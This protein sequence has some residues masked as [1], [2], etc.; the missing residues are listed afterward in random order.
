VGDFST[1]INEAEVYKS[2]GLLEE[3]MGVYRRLLADSEALGPEEEQA[4]REKLEEI[5]KDLED[6]EERGEEGV[7]KEEI[8]VIKESLSAQDNVQTI[9]DAAF[10]F[11]EL[12]LYEEAVGEYTRL[13]GMD[14]PGE[15]VIPEIAKCLMKLHSPE[16]ASEAAVNIIESQALEGRKEAQLKFRL[17]VEMEKVGHPELAIKLYKSALALDPKENR[18]KNRL[19]VLEKRQENAP[20]KRE[21]KPAKS[22][23]EVKDRRREERFIPKIP[24]F[25]FVEFELPDGPLKGKIMR[26]QVLNYSKHGLALLV[27]GKDKKLLELLKPGDKIKNVAFY[28]RW[29]IIKVEVLIKHITRLEDGFHKGHYIIGVESDEII[30]SSR[31]LS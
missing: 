4:I 13:F 9:L 28:A 12:G 5:Q 6:Q 30:E 18:I 16:K 23:P 29:A 10:A 24:E 17:G 19:V 8:T 7:S 20:G 2:M 21:D 14:Y 26:L 25:V 27:T 31:A 15:K 1:S 3:A 22:G 11:K